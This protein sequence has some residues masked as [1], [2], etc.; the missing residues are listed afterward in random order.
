MNS[1][2]Q[3]D[4]KIDVG[5]LSEAQ[6]TLLM[7]LWARAMEN[8]SERPL[9]RDTKAAQIVDS[10]DFDF[11][12][13]RSESV[14]VVDYCLR[15]SV[16]DQ[17]VQR[18][19]VANPRGA[20]AE[21]GVGLDTRFERLDNAEA[22][23]WELDLTDVMRIRRRF[24]ENG[25]RRT[26][27]AGSLLDDDWMEEIAEHLEGPILF[28]CEGVFY[29]F[30]NSQVGEIVAKLADRFPGNG[31]VFDAQSPLFLR[32]SNWRHPL[33]DSHLK[34]A[35]G[36]VRRIAE[37]DRRLRVEQYVGFGDSPYYDDGMP[38]QSALRRW[39]R[40]LLPPVRHLFKVVHATW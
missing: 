9:L 7:P 35:L 12:R 15:A 21:L 14:P 3:T 20:I 16:I 2:L 1:C 4:E 5:R 10:L 11:D 39:A 25:P 29:F 37:W 24:F 31:I 8:R 13:F 34:F 38:R 32:V 28:V 18:F 30:D 36:N 22:T 19:L 17:I 26:M 27:I 40:R 33:S 23:W 6:G